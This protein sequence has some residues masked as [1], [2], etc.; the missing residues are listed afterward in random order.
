MTKTGTR[1]ATAAHR[2]SGKRRAAITQRPTAGGKQPARAAAAGAYHHGAL[3]EALLSAAERILERDGLPG[4]TLR[5]AAREAGVS[6]AA[7]THH[8]GDLTGL[9]SE[10]AAVGFHRFRA[11]LA[12][13][14]Q[15]EASAVARLDAMGRAYVTFAR[16]HPGLFTLMFRSERLDPARPAL[17]EAM[18]AAGAA[19]VAA[20]SA[21]RQE[22]ITR[23]APSLEQVAAV[24]RTWSKVHGFAVLMLDGR[25]RQFL[26]RLPPGADE[27]ALLSAVLKPDPPAS[28]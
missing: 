17:Q 4:L 19:L 20:V 10:L 24:V 13:E 25:L 22:V 2:K 21:R 6:H 15:P 7:P 11:A 14:A 5:A 3:R 26:S 18:D 28:R 12:A 9:L 16:S 23:E 27:M 8:F 1:A